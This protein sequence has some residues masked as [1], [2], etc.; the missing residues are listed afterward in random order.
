MS[1]II[2]SILWGLIYIAS[3]FPLRFF[4]F[5]SDVA[6]FFLHYVFRYRR[7]TIDINLARSF[8]ELK[9]GE[10]AR[11]RKQYYQYMCDIAVESVWVITAS[12]EKLCSLV[13][14]ENTEL[15][16][17]L[18]EEHGNVMAIMGHCGNWELMGTLCGATS[19]RTPVTL[20]GS[21][22]VIAYKA[23]E[24]LAVDNLLRKIR[25]HQFAK[26]GNGGE[27][28]ESKRILRHI[29]KDKSKRNLYVF[30]AD[31]SPLPGERVTAFFLNQPSLMLSGP[32]YVAL[33][34]NLPVVY[35]STQRVGRGKYVFKFI[36][37]TTHAAQTERSF[38]TREYAKL[39][40]KD[41][42]ANKYN[43]LWSHKRWKRAFEPHE[44]EEY[45]EYIKKLKPKEEL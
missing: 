45:N 30:I 27:V 42:F 9:Y 36:P 25:M 28:V 22:I 23:A 32:E 3:F 39:L 1:K 31:Q 38:V 19:A 33:K 6:A 44:Q 12:R 24:N 16:N 20:A 2:Y 8:P 40:E 14:L 43:W 34:M 41:I 29:L 4:Y 21:K 18:Y 5:L 35:L 26:V 7:S 15:V 17:R 37:I 13:H 11:I 10:F